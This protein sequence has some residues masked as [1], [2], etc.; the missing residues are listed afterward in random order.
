MTPIEQR[1]DVKS[2]MGSG[3]QTAQDRREIKAD[4]VR[5]FASSAIFKE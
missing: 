2:E 5:R 4:K 1:R 3:W